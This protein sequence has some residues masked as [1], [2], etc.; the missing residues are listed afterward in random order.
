MGI[1]AYLTGQFVHKTP[2]QVVVDV[3]GVGYEVNVSLHT[4][5]AIQHLD[6][7]TLLV[8]MQVK[9]DDQVLFG[10]HERSEKELFLLLISISGVGASTA[11]MMLSSLKPDEII[12]L[13]ATG[14]ARSLERV[15][16]IG[17]KTAERIVLELRDKVGK[18]PTEA[19][20]PVMGIQVS[21]PVSEAAMALTA[22][23]I[24]RQ[25]A[26]QAVQRVLNEEPTLT[27][28]EIIIKKALKSI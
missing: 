11:R 22:L 12:R 14:D 1:Y 28:L 27:E 20:S 26:E 4:Y 25:M 23:G 13:I 2:A 6:A 17:K 5:S 24:N 3:Q 15:K 7:G 8:H 21:S 10:F 19:G 9:E 18:W 16:G